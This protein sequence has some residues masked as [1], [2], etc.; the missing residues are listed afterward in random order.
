[1]ALMIRFYTV[2]IRIDTIEKYYPGGVD[3]FV[4][5]YTVLHDKELVGAIF[6][7]MY[8]VDSFIDDLIDFGFTYVVNNEFVDIA[9]VDMLRG[10]TLPCKWLETSIY[11]PQKNNKIKVSTCWL[12]GSKDKEIGIRLSKNGDPSLWGDPIYNS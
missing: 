12:K 1:M 3:A 7:N 11:C 8:D 4:K 10:L 6:M 5:Y 2:V 9:V